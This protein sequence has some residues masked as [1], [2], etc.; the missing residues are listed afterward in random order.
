MMTPKERREAFKRW[1]NLRR[2]ADGAPYSVNTV[3]TYASAL[4]TAPAKL[5]CAPLRTTDIFS[6]SDS[7]VYHEERV[8]MEAA[9]N[10]ESVNL[11]SGNRAL[12]YALSRY[13][14][15]LQETET[16][17]EDPAPDGPLFGWTDFYEAFAKAL[18]PWRSDRAGL[19]G[20]IGDAC[21]SLGVGNPFRE[22]S[23]ALCD[24][25]CPFTVFGMFNKGL[26]DDNRRKIAAALA[27]RLG[28]PAPAPFS[29][30]GI[31]VLSNMNARFF[32]AREERGERDIENLWE[33]F[34]RALS[35]PGP[36]D[37]PDGPARD[38]FLGAYDLVR[39]QR[40][41]AWNVTIGLYWASPY[42][43]LPLDLNSR[44]YLRGRLDFRVD[45]KNPPT[46]EAY[47]SLISRFL[48]NP[49]TFG[50]P[51]YPVHSFPELSH[52]A[53]LGRSAPGDGGPE[54]EET[55]SD[56]PGEWP[57]S[58]NVILYGPP[59]TGKTYRS[60][61]FA[62]AAIERK[63]P[64]EVEGA[65][66]ESPDAV[67]GR[68]RRYRDEGRIEFVTFHQSFSYEEFIE[69]IRPALSGDA[70]LRYELRDGIFKAF[71]RHAETVRGPCVFVIDEINRGNISRIFGELITLLEPS[72]R[73]GRPEE[74]LVRLPYSGERFG[75][76]DNVFL[77]GTM[78]TADRS[79]AL[80]DTALRRRFNFVEMAPD[81]SLLAGIDVAGLDLSALLSCI[82]RRIEALYDRKHRIGHA[83]FLPL[84]EEPTM[85]RLAHIFENT[86]LP[87]LQEYFFNDYEKIRL[88]LGDNQKKNA[89][90]QFV[91]ADSLDGAALFGDASVTE[92]ERVFSLN[93]AAF[94]N[95]EAYRKIAAPQE[96]V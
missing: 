94:S 66:R 69:G 2:K 65:L 68:Y 64:A 81:E 28:V 52:Q 16:R 96:T 59:G 82:N 79:I 22:R 24:D 76:P 87:L 84:G 90:E 17:E 49:Y 32:S 25:V 7:R 88:I 35:L 95:P 14:T 27:G 54:T 12:Q 71:C 92:D 42:R 50:N 91:L 34:A 37:A 80:I 67:F 9:E 83:Y 62:V 70:R 73:K 15:F 74:L 39:A 30:S 20:L 60:A 57:M 89:D 58:R 29:F 61:A 44:N 13:E 47:L 86:L 40:G 77:I 78:N 36:D 51:T 55:I 23:G 8:K 56:A 10:F 53:W 19:L 6:L 93:R 26:R 21:A 38:A 75:I 72:K 18:L 33:L 31:P 43:F 41:I 3:D 5:R 1:M 63:R 46:G 45:L 85:E 11:A 48:G 4:A